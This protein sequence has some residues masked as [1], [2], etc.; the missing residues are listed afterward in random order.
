MTLFCPHC[1]QL[2]PMSL[3]RAVAKTERARARE[4]GGKTRAKNANMVKI[5][6]RGG[7]AARGKSGRKPKPRCRCGMYTVGVAA[8]R[9]HKC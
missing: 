7:I 5:G 3:R 8:K 6:R 4:L 2:I 1:A 9:N